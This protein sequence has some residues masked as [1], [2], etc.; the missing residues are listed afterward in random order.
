MILKVESLGAF[1]FMNSNWSPRIGLQNEFQ[2][3]S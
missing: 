2:M 1:A 3:L